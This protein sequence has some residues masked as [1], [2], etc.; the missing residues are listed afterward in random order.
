MAA[1]TCA[2]ARACEG[3]P[4][5]VLASAGAFRA[6]CVARGP[7]TGFGAIGGIA[8]SAFFAVSTTGRRAREER[9]RGWAAAAGGRADGAGI[10][11]TS[12]RCSAPPAR[13]CDGHCRNA[14]AGH[15]AAAC[16]TAD[17][18]RNGSR[19]R[20]GAVIAR[21]DIPTTRT[22]CARASRS[23]SRVHSC[24]PARSQHAG[25]GRVGGSGH[26]AQ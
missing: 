25:R 18:S 19:R 5:T 4:V 9:G 8:N 23:P 22:R 3:A 1:R 21:R 26:S 12:S 13:G 7:D 2:A 24:D 11:R 16:A 15:K 17:S 14:R 6:V 10:S 20:Q